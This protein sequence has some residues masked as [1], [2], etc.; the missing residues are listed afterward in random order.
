MVDVCRH[1]NSA[2]PLLISSASSSTPDSVERIRDGRTP[3]A[4]LTAAGVFVPRRVI[5]SL[6]CSTV[7]V[8]TRGGKT[9]EGDVGVKV[10]TTAVYRPAESV[11]VYV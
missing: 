1:W 4:L 8:V 5:Q 7:P 6:Y 9:V 2:R 10:A 11:V 3:H